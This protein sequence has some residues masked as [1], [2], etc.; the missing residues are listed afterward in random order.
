ML[1]KLIRWARITKAGSDDKAFPVQQMEYRGK[2]ADGLIIFPY[3]LH[4]NVPAD[5]LALMFSVGGSA[6]NRAAI[7]YTPTD[8]PKLADG[9]VAFYHPPTDAHMIW[10]DGGHLEIVTGEGGS[11]NITITCDNADITAT[12]SA[13]VTTTTATLTASGAATIDSPITTFTGDVSILGNLTV[14]LAT[15]LISVLTVTG[16]ATMGAMTSNG[17][18]VGDTHTHGGSATAPDGPVSATGAPQ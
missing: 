15:T 5:S 14:T 12:T 3:G 8:R 16:A 9:E 6:D 18:N 7:A 13:T 1:S 10:R 2:V 17:K 4:G 11:G